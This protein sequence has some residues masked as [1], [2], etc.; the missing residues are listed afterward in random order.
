MLSVRVPCIKEFSL[1]HS[2]LQK[3]SEYKHLFITTKTNWLQKS[4]R[5]WTE[6]TVKSS[7]WSGKYSFSNLLELH[8]WKKAW[9]FQRSEITRPQ[10]AKRKLNRRSKI[11]RDL[12]ANH[13]S[14]QR[15]V[16][17]YHHSIVSLSYAT[18]SIVPIIDFPRWERCWC[19]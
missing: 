2:W 3:R 15:L 18:N 10:I 8:A 5:H 17:A 1:G 11:H 12:I 13:G 14:L 16:R 6:T 9:M 4:A 7:K 19:N